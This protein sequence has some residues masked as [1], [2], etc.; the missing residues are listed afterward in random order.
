M[1]IGVVSVAARNIEHGLLAA[2]GMNEDNTLFE[3]NLDRS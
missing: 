3:S 1:V 2:L